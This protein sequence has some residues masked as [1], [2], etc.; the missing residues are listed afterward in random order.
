MASEAQQKHLEKAREERNKHQ[1]LLTEIKDLKAELEKHKEVGKI[2]LDDSF[3]WRKHSEQ[4]DSL[5]N[6]WPQLFNLLLDLHGNVTSDSGRELW[7][8]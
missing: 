7:K 8:G 2:F 5:R 4:T 6:S 3:S 1:A